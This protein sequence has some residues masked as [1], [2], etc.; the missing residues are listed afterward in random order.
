VL[1]DVEASAYTGTGKRFRGRLICTPACL[2]RVAKELEKEADTLCP[3]KRIE[4]PFGEGIEFNYARVTRLVLNAF[5]LS[6]TAA[7][8]SINTMRYVYY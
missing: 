4:T 6:R 1:N 3:F 5:G 2:Q 7:Q 8:R